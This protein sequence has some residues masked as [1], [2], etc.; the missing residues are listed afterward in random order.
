MLCRQI[1]ARHMKTFDIGQKEY[2]LL[3]N[4]PNSILRGK[5]LVMIATLLGL[6]NLKT[7]MMKIGL[8]MKNIL[9]FVVYKPIGVKLGDAVRITGSKNMK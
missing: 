4:W 8:P 6:M 9:R 1:I 5:R 3:R 7:S 2:F